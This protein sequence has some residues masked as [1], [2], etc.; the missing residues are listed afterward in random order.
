MKN[1]KFKILEKIVDT[2]M[3]EDILEECRSFWDYYDNDWNI[4]EPEEEIIDY[5][6]EEIEEEPSDKY[7]VR[8]FYRGK[9]PT[10]MYKINKY[11]YVRKI[12]MMSIYPIDVLR[13][14][15]IDIILSE[16]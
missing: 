16:D 7:V 14:K 8:K 11:E 9:V 1:N 10:N 15:K 12:D 13:N 4:N 5:L 2:E 6:Y 3:K